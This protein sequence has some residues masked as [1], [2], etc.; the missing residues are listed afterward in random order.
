MGNTQNDIAPLYGLVLM[1]GR[2]HRMGTNKAELVYHDQAQ[3]LHLYKLVDTFCKN[4][5]LSLNDSKSIYKNKNIKVILDRNRYTGPYNGI[6]SAHE[7]HP[8]AAWLVV[9]CDLPFL[10]ENELKTLLQGRNPNKPA[11]ALTAKATGIP[12]PLI[13]IWEPHGLLSAKKYIENVGDNSPKN[14]LIHLGAERV[15]AENEECLFN[16]NTM[17]DYEYAKRRMGNSRAME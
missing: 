16:A 4:T 2:S 5:F 6:M 12:E 10:G 8:E 17:A 9:A 13:C 7:A 14:F 11:T 1:G 15:V 3:Y